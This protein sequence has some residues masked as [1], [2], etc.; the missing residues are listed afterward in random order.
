VKRWPAI[1]HP[2]SASQKLQG[3][4]VQSMPR[5]HRLSRAWSCIKQNKTKQCAISPPACA[6]D[7]TLHGAI[8]VTRGAGL[9]E[10]LAL[11]PLGEQNCRIDS[12]SEAV[13]GKFSLRR[14]PIRR[15]ALASIS[16]F[17]L[18]TLSFISGS[19]SKRLVASLVHTFFVV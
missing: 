2:V 6:L 4:P 18:S 9:F 13:E 12:D 15:S 10:W 5:S 3:G 11:E 19:A 14:L 16:S 17:D 1:V 7:R 8:D